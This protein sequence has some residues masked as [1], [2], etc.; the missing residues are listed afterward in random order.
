MIKI[1]LKESTFFSQIKAFESCTEG[2]NW[3]FSLKGPNKVISIGQFW[4]N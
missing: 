2:N 1:L 4:I 3:D